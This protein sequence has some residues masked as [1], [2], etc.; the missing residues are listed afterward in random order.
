MATI[1]KST[2]SLS[3][4]QLLRERKKDHEDIIAKAARITGLESEVENLKTSYVQVEASRD[5]YKK[6]FNNA[7]TELNHLRGRIGKADLD[8]QNM[9][10]L[11]E[12]KNKRIQ[13][14]KQSIQ[15]M[16]NPDQQIDN[17]H[18]IPYYSDLPF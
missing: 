16:V 15:C 3:R 12:S 7:Q 18:I 2:K 5:I 17:N 13:E 9:D 1:K 11:I 14:L 4:A 10:I 6:N 8:I